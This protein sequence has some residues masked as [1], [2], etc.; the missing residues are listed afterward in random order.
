ML[1]LSKRCDNVTSNTMAPC[2]GKFYE[3]RYNRS[4]PND[5]I[6]MY[7]N[8]SMT[9]FDGVELLETVTGCQKP[10]EKILY[11]TNL[12]QTVDSDDL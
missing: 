3:Q 12:V 7:H 8:W 11:S 2:V 10:C 9:S 5:L 6:K 1:K 4:D